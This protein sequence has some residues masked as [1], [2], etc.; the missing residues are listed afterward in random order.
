MSTAP[1][2]VQSKDSALS[3]KGLKAGS[4]GL[5]GAVVI[6][7]SC[8]APAYTL[9]AALGP[10]VSEVG[11]HLPAIF[12]VGFIP[13]LL[14]ALGYRE[15]NNAM[16][17]A[18]TSFT[19]ATRAFG[20]WIGWMGGWGLIAAT[21]I[22]LSNLAAVAVDFFYLMLGQVFS[23]PSLADLSK[24][25]PLN[26]ATTLVF[27][28]VA[29]WISY[30]G[31]ETTKGVQ[32]VLVA[33]QLLVLGWFA[34]S[35]FSH[36]ANGTAFDA[37]AISPDWF[38]PFAVDSFT[39][40]TAG[41]SL[42]IFIYWGWDVTL[43]MN[44]ETRNPEKTP[45]RAATVTVLVIVIIYMTVALATLSFAGVGD[46]G[47]GAGNPENQSS[48]FAV[49]AGPVMGPFAILMSLA[50]LS[51][52]AA[53][54]Q[55][56][57]VSPARTLLAMGHYRA[58]SPKFGRISPTF[59]SP[60]TAT[61]AAAIA[62]AGFYVITRTVSENAL[63]DTITA[64]GM[65]ICFY[66]GI[67]ALACVWYFR[68]SA[69]SGV[70]S[71]FFKFLA[72]LLGGVILLVMFVKTAVDSLDPAYGSGSSVGGIG[73]VFILGMGVILLGVVVMLVMYRVRPEFFRNFSR[74]VGN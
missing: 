14:V 3:E 55:S 15:L 45:G 62:A 52:S 72:P 64:L 59:K 6:G 1:K 44:E 8:I 13:M 23:N 11:V 61:I 24:I 47:L 74:R 7:V 5:I 48:I 49:L 2:T 41:V 26:I 51:S 43:T 34:V 9:T 38:N 40:F 18:G 37:T 19:W 63:W 32:Y 68:A 60:S 4:V 36:V 29:C 35:A 28:A 57:F 71:F 54:L 58:I 70:R 50:I 31:M 16:P 22:V 65:M 66:Y 69:F 33:F 12:L 17:D 10:T 67:T 42:S 20:P 73:L 27:I 25:L 30:R 21:I 53:S 46:T 56:T 39:T